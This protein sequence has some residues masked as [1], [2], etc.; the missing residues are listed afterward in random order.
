MTKATVAIGDALRTGKPLA[1]AA[2]LIA[3]HSRRDVTADYERA[4]AD[5]Q[6]RADSDVRAQYLAQLMPPQNTRLQLRPDLDPTPTVNML[7]QRKFLRSVRAV[8]D[9]V[10]VVESFAHGA[11]TKEGA[12]ALRT[13]YPGLYKRTVSDIMR[14]ASELKKA[15]S[16]S[17]QQHLS[18]L[19]GQPLHFSVHPDFVRFAQG[20]YASAAAAGQS[21]TDMLQDSSG[22]RTA[23]QI[24]S[25][26]ATQ[27]QT[28]GQRLENGI[29]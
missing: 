8:N 9:P 11:G 22:P 23:R 2:K 6:K 27:M 17:S 24:N 18:V 1:G 20:A 16:M 10:S 5:V 12:Q 21:G 4:V 7:D 28:P 13:L 19:V 14:H 3:M 29:S 15:P 26:V 25:K